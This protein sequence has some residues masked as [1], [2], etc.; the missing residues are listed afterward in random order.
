[1]RIGVIGLGKL[2]LPVAEAMAEYHDVVGYDVRPKTVPF[3]GTLR[4]AAQG[5]FIFVAV[6]T[7]HHPIYGGEA[8][9]S[10]LPPKDFDYGPL[11][12]ALKALAN[13]VVPTQRIVVISTCM[14]G[15]IRDLAKLVPCPLLFNPYFIAMGTVKR[16]FLNPEM[17]V[18]GSENGDDIEGQELRNFYEPMVKTDHWIFCRYEEAEA[19][20]VFFNVFV[21]AR[22]SLVNTILDVSEKMGMDAGV[23]CGAFTKSKKQRDGYW[24]PGMGD[25]GPCHERDVAALRH[26]GKRVGLTYDP[27][28]FILSAREHQAENLARHLVSF[29]MPV[30]ILGK[31]FKPGTDLTDGSYSLLVGHYVEKLGCEVAYDDSGSHM[32][33]AYLLGHR[34]RFHDYD[35]PPGSVIVDPWGEC[36]EIPL[37]SVYRYGREAHKVEV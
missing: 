20:K 35:Y 19:I 16:D 3:A 10:H 12:T 14:P 9:T 17:M 25:G 5:D 24:M 33:K 29:E 1:M 27:F 34:G 31:S 6:Q 36:P 30:V 37:C 22:L 21:A 26:F 11:T 13:Y 28:A 7:P 8:P 2:G 18:V 23:I 4:E 32:P 15:T